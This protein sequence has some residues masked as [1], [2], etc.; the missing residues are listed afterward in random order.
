MKILASQSAFVSSEHLSIVFQMGGSN[1]STEGSVFWGFFFLSKKGWKGAIV[2]HT[3]ACRKAL[4]KAMLVMGPT[5]KSSALQWNVINPD[6][7]KS[8]YMN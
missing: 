4:Y 6:I 5:G 8:F 7:S 2:L 1:A 3:F